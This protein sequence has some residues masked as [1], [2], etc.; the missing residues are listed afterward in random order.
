[1]PDDE[2]VRRPPLVCSQRGVPNR[3]VTSY[4]RD[5]SAEDQDADT[6]RGDRHDLATCTLQGRGGTADSFLLCLCSVLPATRGP[7]DRSDSDDGGS[8][9]DTNHGRTHGFLIGLRVWRVDGT[10]RLMLRR[11]DATG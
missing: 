2:G 3:A 8:R 7:D 4:G 5:W 11:C 10:G 9:R 6:A 1:M